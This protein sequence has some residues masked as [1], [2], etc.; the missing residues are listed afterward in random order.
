MSKGCQYATNDDKV[1]I[2]LKH[3]NVKNVQASLQKIITLTKKLGNMRHVLENACVE[4][5]YS[6]KTKKN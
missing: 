5:N 3:V 4:N 1:A 6:T 2:R